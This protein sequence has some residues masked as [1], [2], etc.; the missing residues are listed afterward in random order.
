MNM[1]D[2]LVTIK[3]AHGM[4]TS[5]C[6]TC[7]ALLCRSPCCFIR[8]S[9]CFKIHILVKPVHSYVIVSM[10][11]FKL[12]NW[13]KCLVKYLCILSVYG[14]FGVTTFNELLQI[15]SVS[16]NTGS[17]Y[18]WSAVFCSILWFSWCYVCTSQRYQL[19]WLRFY[20]FPWSLQA[21]G[22]ILP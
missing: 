12:Y 7:R 10:K 21:D 19:F 8:H 2:V 13:E 5:Q 11:T 1:L 4:R 9:H 16:W 6:V 14:V 15:H 18:V 3:C 17:W 22:R 20:G